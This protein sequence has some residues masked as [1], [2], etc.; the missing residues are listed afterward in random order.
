M[1]IGHTSSY[2]ALQTALESH[3]HQA[4]LLNGAMGIGKA[5][6][7]KNLALSILVKCSPFTE[8]VVQQQCMNGSYPNYFYISRISD[9][10]GKQKHEITIE[11]VRTLL[12]SLK[13]KAAIQGQ[14]I[15]VIDAI[16]QM[17]R[18]AANALLKILEEPPQDTLFL[19]VCHSLGSVLPTIRSRCVKIDFKPLS[20]A[21]MRKISAVQGG[22]VD[23][24]ILEMAAGAPGIYQKIH[25]VGG[26][27]ILQSI[28]R[29][30]HI[31]NLND[32]KSAL[33]DLL[34]QSDDSFLGYLLQ[35]FMYQKALKEP[36]VYAHSAQT[37]EKF[38]RYT[39]GTH[40]DGAHRLVA[41]VL[42]ARNPEYKQIIYG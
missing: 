23:S 37:V 18:Q 35:Q 32:L 14:R 40:L 21:D 1:I 6:I 15:I 38:M 27:I 10:E 17:N 12:N 2:T 41:A 8:N 33:Q 5:S 20:A 34:K 22:E 36:E 24:T 30:F 25:E 11:Q 42:L 9:E 39:N 7:A 3:R 31:S 29:L 26:A 13:K 28:E 4:F 19:L 16:D